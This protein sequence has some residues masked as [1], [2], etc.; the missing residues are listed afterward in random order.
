MQ[1]RN[2]GGAVVSELPVRKAEDPKTETLKTGV[3]G[4]I[5]LE[6]G[7]MTVEAEAIGLDDQAAI[8]PEE[9]DFIW[10]DTR[11]DLRLGK[12]VATTDGEEDALELG[13]AEVLLVSEIRR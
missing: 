12:A 1:S 11:V 7:A 5:S 3:L 10:A 9:V 6:G 4:A 2:D 13:A 8:T